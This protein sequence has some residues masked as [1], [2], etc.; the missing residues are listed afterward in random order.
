MANEITSTYIACADTRRLYRSRLLNRFTGI[1]CES[2]ECY[3]NYPLKFKEMLSIR[4]ISEQPFSQKGNICLF[5]EQR[6]L[7]P[8]LIAIS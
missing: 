1:D 5:F 6:F 4:A 3:G 2:N 8:Q 7:S